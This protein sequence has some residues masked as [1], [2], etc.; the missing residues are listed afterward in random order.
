MN[1]NAQQEFSTSIPALLGQLTCV[2]RQ[3]AAGITERILP[4]IPA[5]VSSHILSKVTFRVALGTAP[6]VWPEVAA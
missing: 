2:A 5:Q 1:S 6:Q 3:I 4:R